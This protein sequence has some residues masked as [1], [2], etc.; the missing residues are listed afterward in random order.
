MKA[1]Y[2]CYEFTPPWGGASSARNPLGIRASG[3]T[4]PLGSIGIAS[5][6]QFLLPWGSLECQESFGD[7]GLG[8]HRPSGGSRGVTSHY[9]FL[10]PWGSFRCQKFFRDLSLWRHR[11]SGGR[12][13]HPALPVSAPL[14]ELCGRRSTTRSGQK[15]G[16]R[17]SPQ[18]RLSRR[19]TPI[20]SQGLASCATAT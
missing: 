14:G 12:E 18:G 7:S 2:A 16:L 15:T 6:Y 1:H 4:D 11:P 17:K 10:P 3:A 9:Q 8:R 19:G 13:A 5:H 20:R